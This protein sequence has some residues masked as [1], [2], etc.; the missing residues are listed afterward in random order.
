MVV[1]RVLRP[2]GAFARYLMPTQAE[3]A[4]CGAL[5]RPWTVAADSMPGQVANAE[6]QKNDA[7]IAS[8]ARGISELRTQ[9][10]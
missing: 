6:Q 9:R 5:E 8:P 3:L 10:Y 4:R 7:E 1:G 2:T